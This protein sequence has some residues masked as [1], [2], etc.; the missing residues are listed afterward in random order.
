MLSDLYHTYFRWQFVVRY[1]VINVCISNMYLPLY[2]YSILI[3]AAQE[4]ASAN[5]YSNVSRP[6]R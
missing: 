4:Q 3:V 5:S 2:T 6:H 1:H